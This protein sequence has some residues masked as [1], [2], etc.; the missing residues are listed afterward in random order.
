MANNRFLVIQNFWVTQL[1][2]RTQVL[3]AVTLLHVSL[4]T[5]LTKLVVNFFSPI[6]I[7][8]LLLTYF[9]KSIMVTISTLL[10]YP[11]Q[12]INLSVD[13]FIFHLKTSY[14]VIYQLVFIVGFNQHW[15]LLMLLAAVVD[16]MFY[17]KVSALI[18]WVFFLILSV[19][20]IYL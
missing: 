18:S 7:L 13:L 5:H 20:D 8:Q 15:V 12:H 6:D 4:E 11:V 2:F 9:N 1:S 10:M 16:G 3:R 17:R 14:S 19:G